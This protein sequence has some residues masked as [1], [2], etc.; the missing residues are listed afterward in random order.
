[1]DTTGRRPGATTE[2][3]LA[4]V[5]ARFENQTALEEELRSRLQTFLQTGTPPPVVFDT[6]W[7]E[8]LDHQEPTRVKYG[9]IGSSLRWAS[10]SAADGVLLRNRNTSRHQLSLGTTRSHRAHSRGTFRRALACDRVT[11]RQTT[12]GARERV[13]GWSTWQAEDDDLAGRIEYR[14]DTSGARVCRPVERGG[15]MRTSRRPGITPYRMA[16]SA[17]ASF[18]SREHTRFWGQQFRQPLTDCHRSQRS[19]P[20]TL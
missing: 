20:G 5:L 16:P 1:V 10:G 2:G 13:Y 18:S 8:G 15:V 6:E 14:G 19:R 3:N 7:E 11:G 17:S 4:I 9:S 12:A